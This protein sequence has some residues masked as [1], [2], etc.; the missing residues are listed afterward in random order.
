MHYCVIKK[1][2]TPGFECKWQLSLTTFWIEDLPFRISYSS[3]QAILVYLSNIVHKLSRCLPSTKSRTDSPCYL[4]L[5]QSFLNQRWH[6]FK[7]AI[8]SAT[9][10]HAVFR[11]RISAPDLINPQQYQG[12]IGT[13]YTREYEETREMRVATQSHI[14][15]LSHSLLCMGN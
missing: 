8:S 5:H 2:Q 1:T 12:Y 7:A 3:R 10:F 13:D 6:V 4:L 15:H 9:C 11:K 14:Q